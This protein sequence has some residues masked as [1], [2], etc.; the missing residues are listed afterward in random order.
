MWFFLTCQTLGILTDSEPRLVHQVQEVKSAVPRIIEAVR[1]LHL[2][3]TPNAR[4]DLE[5]SCVAYNDWD[6]DTFRLGRPVVAIFQGQEIRH[7]HGEPLL[8]EEDF[9]LGGEFTRK[10]EALEA[11]GSLFLLY[12]SALNHRF[13]SA[14]GRHAPPHFL[15]VFPGVLDRIEAGLDRSGSRAWRLCS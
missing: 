6:E 13:L 4:V 12:L 3:L 2:P 5:M 15:T 10:A 9:N 1:Q 7:A 11:G 8:R 14:F